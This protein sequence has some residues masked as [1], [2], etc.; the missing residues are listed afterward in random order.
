MRE[1]ER[2][3]R[4][5][6]EKEMGVRSCPDL[7]LT[8]SLPCFWLA[9]RDKVKCLHPSICGLIAH[10]GGWR[11]RDQDSEGLT[12]TAGQGRMGLTKLRELNLTLSPRGNCRTRGARRARAGS[13][14]DRAS[15][16]R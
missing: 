12:K 16:R 1:G 3:T 10:L 8:Q 14:E 15:G 7:A 13:R 5:R 2:S 4:T 11:K 6:L 9:A